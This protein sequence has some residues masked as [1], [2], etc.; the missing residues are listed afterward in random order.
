MAPF[1]YVIPF[2]DVEVRD[3]AEG[4]GTDVDVG[5]GFDLAGAADDREKI[6]AGDLGGRGLL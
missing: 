5:L 4:G 6:F 3:A 2:L 1:F